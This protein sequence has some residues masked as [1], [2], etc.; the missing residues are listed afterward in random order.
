[1]GRKIVPTGEPIIEDEV[2]DEAFQPTAKNTNVKS[3]ISDDLRTLVEKTPAI[4]EVYFMA[5]G[6]YTLTAYPHGE[7][8]YGRIIVGSKFGTTPML[9]TLIV[10][11]VSRKYITGK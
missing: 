8:L 2:S 5:N 9:D 3:L 4:K 6:G 10:E 7:S 11:V 1:M